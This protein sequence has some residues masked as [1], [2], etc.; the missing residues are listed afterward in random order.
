MKSLNHADLA[1]L[2][3]KAALA[4]RQRAHLNFHPELS[5]P[6]QRLAIAMEPDTYVRPHRHLHSFELLMS[7]S[8]CFDLLQFDDQG[9]V[10]ARHRLGADGLALCE[11]AA[12][13][14][15]SVVSLT[16]GSV[17]FE[18]KH[19]PYIPPSPADQASWSPVEGEPAV[20]GLMA[21]MREAKVGDRFTA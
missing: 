17:I 7:L 6:I 10:L 4:P 12:G 13:V 15:H 18:I 8:G 14:W 1:A 20:A 11:Q 16:P 21:F 5:D 9:V 19:G 2:T 3:A